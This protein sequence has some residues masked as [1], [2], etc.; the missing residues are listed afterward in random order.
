MMCFVHSVTVCCPEHIV[1]SYSKGLNQMKNKS[2]DIP[3]K[4]F[5][6]DL[7][8]SDKIKNGVKS[9]FFKKVPVY[10]EEENMLSSQSTKTSTRPS[11][12]DINE[13]ALSERGI[14]ANRGTPSAPSSRNSNTAPAVKIAYIPKD[15]VIEGNLSTKSDIEIY[16]TIKGTVVSEGHIKVTGKIEGDVFAN[17]LTL[18][19][20]MIKG[21]IECKGN[22]TLNGQS[23]IVGNILSGSVESD[24]EIQGD[25]KA[26]KSVLLKTNAVT[27][28][29]IVT[30]M[31]NMH[32]GSVLR[33]LVEMPADKIAEL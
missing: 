11:S 33:G 1:K 5:E 29:N 30:K 13:S 32:D 3:A 18:T 12:G 2:M 28:G 21:N 9:L 24:G 20:G 17:G 26:S 25:I 6:E 15:S 27:C 8:T 16:G 14:S 31:I 19:R 10:P 7:P 22:V 23:V 4:N